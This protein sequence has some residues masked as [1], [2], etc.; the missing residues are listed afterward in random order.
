ML[1]VPIGSRAALWGVQ[2]AKH[3]KAPRDPALYSTKKTL[4][5][6][7]SL[8][9]FSVYF[10]T[11]TQKIHENPERVKI[12]YFLFQQKV[13]L[14]NRYAVS[15]HRQTFLSPLHCHFTFYEGSLFLTQ[16]L[17]SVICPS[18]SVSGCNL[19]NHCSLDEVSRKVT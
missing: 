3:P 9:I 11:N 14:Q 6:A 17:G 18:T 8:C 7:L 16:S 4:K 1:Q 12:Y 19:K 10:I 2:G 5:I 15:L 13:L